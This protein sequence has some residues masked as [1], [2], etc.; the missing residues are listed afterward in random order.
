M[1]GAGAVRRGLTFATGLA[2]CLCFG[3]LFGWSSLVFVLKAEGYFGSWCDVAPRAN[4]ATLVQ[5][6][7]DNHTSAYS[8]PQCRAQHEWLS[9]VFAVASNLSNVLMLPSGFLL[10]RFGTAVA[11]HVAT[12]LFTTGNLMVAFS[13]P[14]S[15][16]LLFP[17][18]TLMGVGG[19]LF[20]M[21]NMQV[22]NLFSSHQTTVT[23]LYNGAFDSSAALFVVIKLLHE[24]GISLRTS[25]LCLSTGS[26]TGS[27][28]RTV[29]LM[30]RDHIPYPL[31]EDYTYGI[32]CGTSKTLHSK[33]TMT[34]TEEKN[35][36]DEPVTQEKSFSECLMSRLY[37]SQLLWFSVI[38]LRLLFYVGTLQPTLHRLAAGQLSL[39][40]HF[41][42]AFGVTQLCGVLCAPWNGLISSQ[43]KNKPRAA[44]ESE[45]EVDLRSVVFSLS[46]TVLQ[47]VLFSV[48]AAVPNLR[49]QYLTFVL[50]VV[51]RAF[52]Y[53]TNA[54]FILVAFPLCHFGK[55]YGLCLGLSSVFCLLINIG[56]SLLSGHIL[57]VNIFLTLL[58]LLAFINPLVLH[59]HCRGLASQRAAPSKPL[60]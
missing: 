45:Q 6:Q 38:Q 51:N 31:P 53:G 35:L 57:Y 59:L 47:C 36:P 41:T 26:F 5:G 21:T 55:L 27:L 32:T 40:S 23:N 3:A 8:G 58:V 22:G 28:L 15:S 13:T 12:F 60:L 16:N 39:V 9:L 29:F 33:H 2:E 44:G 4:N 1:P 18:C 11:R 30:P 52:L 42:N 48:C 14:A 50:H 24:A 10:D 20:L 46:L 37:V 43:L 34:T 25:F 17:A 19:T 56:L 54:T 49:L 7:F